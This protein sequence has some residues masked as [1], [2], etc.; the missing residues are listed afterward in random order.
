MGVIV[1]FAGTVGKMNNFFETEEGRKF[2]DMLKR[3]KDLNNELEWLRHLKLLRD[4]EIV[5]ELRIKHEN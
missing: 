3:I 1:I 4:E 2:I 5:H